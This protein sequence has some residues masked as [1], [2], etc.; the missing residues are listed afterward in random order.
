MGAWRGM[1][2]SAGCLQAYK[3]TSSPRLLLSQCI[4]GLLSD[5][6]ILD[7][8]YMSEDVKKALLRNVEMRLTPQPVKVRSDFEVTCFA[9]EGIDAIKASLLEGVKCGTEMN[10]ISVRLIAP[11]LY[12]M[13]CNTLDQ[14]RSAAGEVEGEA[15]GIL[16]QDVGIK[17]LEGALEKIK[18]E[19][20]KR[21][22]LDRNF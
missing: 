6:T 3:R 5:P 11:P 9:Y 8:Y 16:L 14:V 1:W 21:N 19:I 20:L 10:P 7:K 22:V 13:T 4:P 17:L 2:P 15:D 18:E 12:V